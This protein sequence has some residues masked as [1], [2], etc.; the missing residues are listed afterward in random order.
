M[1]ILVNK[2]LWNEAICIE[3]EIQMRFKWEQIH[4]IIILIW[5]RKVHLPLNKLQLQIH[6]ST[7]YVY[8]S[9]QK[10]F[11]PPDDTW[12]EDPAAI[13]F[14]S[15]I[16]WPCLFRLAYFCLRLMHTAKTW[17]HQKNMS[18]WCLFVFV[19]FYFYQICLSRAY[20]VS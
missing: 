19:S 18:P 12:G 9:K 5:K 13:R 3:K 11:I 1:G 14:R 20:K 8:V 16:C 15:Q 4:C 10:W 6:H 2:P 17:G 7:K